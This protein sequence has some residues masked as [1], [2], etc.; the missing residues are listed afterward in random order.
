[1]ISIDIEFGELLVHP[2]PPIKASPDFSIDDPA[3]DRST[4]GD[5]RPQMPCL[6][7]S[8]L[9]TTQVRHGWIVAVCGHGR[10]Q[11]NKAAERNIIARRL[12]HAGFGWGAISGADHAIAF[13]LRRNETRSLSLMSPPRVNSGTGCDGGRHQCVSREDA[14]AQQKQA[15]CEDMA[16]EE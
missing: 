4:R 14:G 1:M 11:K 3:R 7:P 8:G 6:R 5:D 9:R 16:C 2:M 15:H 10:S 12:R 13:A